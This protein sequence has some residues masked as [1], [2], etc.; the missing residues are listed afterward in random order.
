ME[1]DG[2]RN[3]EYK[4]ADQAG[5]YKAYKD[6]TTLECWKLARKVKLFFYQEV[7]HQLPAEEKYNLGSQNYP[8]IIRCSGLS[9]MN[10]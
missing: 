8:I 7:L 6:F 5:T 2:E 4:I 1:V 10:K 9:Q 3:F